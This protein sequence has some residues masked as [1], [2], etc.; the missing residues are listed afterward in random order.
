MNRRWLWLGF[1]AAFL[2]QAGLATWLIVD[3]AL[4]LR[5]GTEVRLAVVPRDPRDLFRGDFIV[6]VFEISRLDTADLAGDDAFATGERVFVELREGDE[7]WQA[8]GLHHA[9]PDGS[10]SI[11][12]VI[13][14]GISCSGGGGCEAYRIRYDIERYFVTEGE[15][16][17]L[18]R[19]RNDQRLAVDVAI[20]GDGEAGLKRLLVD[21]EV[22]YEQPIF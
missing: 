20:A 18:E 15:G 8:A 19:L 4:L 9:Q 16:R 10:L 3:R 17:A 5:R 1:L 7:N 22:R 14:R 21:G 6:L 12:G 2:L 13:E 11:R